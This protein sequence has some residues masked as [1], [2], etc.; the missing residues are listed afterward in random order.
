MHRCS[1]SESNMRH[2]QHES[3]AWRVR[4]MVCCEGVA[5][6]AKMNQ[7][8]SRRFK[9]AKERLEVGLVS[10]PDSSAIQDTT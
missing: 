6:R 4:V 9:A 5:P 7:Q 1:L 3:H 2:C 8:R 10:E